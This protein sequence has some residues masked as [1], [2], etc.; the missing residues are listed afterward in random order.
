MKKLTLAALTA[1]ALS[2]PAF[3]ADNAIQINAPY[4]RITAPT[5]KMGAAFMEITNNTGKDDVLLSTTAPV[6]K[7][8]EI[9]ETSI[10]E[11]GVM[12]M[13]EAKNGIALP[14]GKTVVLQPGGLHIMLMGLKKPLEFGQ[15]YPMTLKFKNAPEQTVTIHVNNGKVTDIST[16]E[17]D[18]SKH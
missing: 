3:A 1:L 2:V 14:A 13:R 17:M 10:D 4:S 12:K 9:H 16:V 7:W 15:T 11:H 18:H 8:T 5:V 6:S